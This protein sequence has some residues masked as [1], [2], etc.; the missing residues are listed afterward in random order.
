MLHHR[1][2]LRGVEQIGSDWPGI[3]DGRIEVNPRI[4]T[5]LSGNFHAKKRSTMCF[6]W[7]SF[8]NI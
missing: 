3:C 2:D 4:G 8:I 1:R 6:I 7:A 5:K